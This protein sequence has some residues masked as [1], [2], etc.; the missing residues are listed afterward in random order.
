MGNPGTNGVGALGASAD[1][2]LPPLGGRSHHPRSPFESDKAGSARTA[3]NL[4]RRRVVRTHL[5]E[6]L[7]HDERIA[8]PPLKLC[9]VQAV[10]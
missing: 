1:L 6:S 4:V 8:G 9:A 7:Q 10:P 3:E 2:V 5:R